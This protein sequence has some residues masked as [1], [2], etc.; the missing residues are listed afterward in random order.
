MIELTKEEFEWLFKNVKKLEDYG[1][2]HPYA[3][4]NHDTMAELAR[5]ME[6]LDGDVDSYS[7][8]I[9]KEALST[10]KD[11]TRQ[12]IKALEEKVIPGYKK[13]M[14]GPLKV[15]KY[16]NYIDKATK[17]LDTVKGIGDKLNV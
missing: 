9:P 11:I 6:L 13:R 5:V 2:A 16:Q 4:K 14:N 7:L 15:K 17:T 1:R 10:I 8:E 3:L 12:S